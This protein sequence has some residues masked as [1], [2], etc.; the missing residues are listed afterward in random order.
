VKKHSPA[1]H[2]VAGK[3]VGGEA[4]RSAMTRPLFGKSPR[5]CVELQLDLVV[6]AEIDL[7]TIWFDV[8]RTLDPS[9]AAKQAVRDLELL[10]ALFVEHASLCAF[11]LD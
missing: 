3:G 11:G 2:T 5:F 10:E 9:A 7:L 8:L 4:D 6:L 1:V